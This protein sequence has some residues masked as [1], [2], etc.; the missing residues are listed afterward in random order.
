MMMRRIRA[1]GGDRLASSEILLYPAIPVEN[2]RTLRA[3]APSRDS[4][5]RR[6]AEKIPKTPG[7]ERVRGHVQERSPCGKPGPSS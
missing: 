7:T 1:L 2:E 5:V 6:Q 3:L 4:E